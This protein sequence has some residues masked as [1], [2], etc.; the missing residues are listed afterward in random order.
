[1]AD[2]WSDYTDNIISIM[3]DEIKNKYGISLRDIFSD[4]TSAL[5]I[6][7]IDT[8]IANA[9]EDV[10]KYIADVDASLADQRKVLADNA[11]KCDS[12]TKQ[13]NQNIMMHTR[14]NNVPLIKPDSIDRDESRDEVIYI[15]NVEN[16]IMNLIGKLIASSN[17]VADFTTNYNEYSIGNWFF[18]GP[19]NYSIRVNLADNPLLILDATKEEVASL[20]DVVKN[21][22]KGSSNQQK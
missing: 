8:K 3:E 9:E 19:K 20:F 18:S 11:S 22:L 4:P 7:N 13:L 12:I 14:Q 5:G 21:I 10:N 17:L 6:D 1:M 15:S 2:L 16:G